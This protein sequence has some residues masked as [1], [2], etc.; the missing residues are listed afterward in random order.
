MNEHHATRT[1]AIGPRR[2]SMI[3][4]LL[5]VTLWSA[6]NVLGQTIQFFPIRSA[7]LGSPPGT[8]G[9]PVTPVFNSALGCWEVQ[10]QAGVEVDLD[11]QGSGWGNAAGSP[12]LVAIQGTVLS[13]GYNN[14]VGGILNPKGWPGSPRNGAYQ[15]ATTC[16]GGDGSPCFTGP[17]GPC[18]AGSCDAN[19]RWIMPPCTIH[20]AAIA[21]PTLNYA[22]AVAVQVDC[23]IDDGMTKTFGGLILDVPNDA[24]GTYVIGLDPAP[25]S[26]FM[27]S[28]LG[29]AIPGVTLTPACIT[30][31]NNNNPGRCCSEI[32]PNVVCEVVTPQVCSTRPQP[33]SFAAGETC[34]GDDA[35]PT[36]ASDGDCGDG[37]A[38]TADVC[39]EAGQC[40]HTIICPE[41]RFYPQRLSKLG[42]PA[43]TIGNSVTPEFNSDLGCWELRV[44]A[45]VEVDID[46]QAFGWGGAP[47]SPTLGAI[48]GTVVSAGYDNGSDGVLNPKGWP[49]SPGDGAYQAGSACS[50]NGDPCNQ[51]F[52]FGCNGGLNGT[53]DHN[54]NWVM[55]DCAADI[56][57]IAA[58]TLDY[59]WVTAA[60]SDCNI[61]DGSVKTMGGLILEVPPDA[62]GTYVIAFDSDPNSSFMT[63]GAGIP[64]PDVALTSA[65]ITVDPP[66]TKNRYLTFAPGESGAVAYKLDMVSSFFHPDAFVSGWIGVPDA[67]GVA[68]LEPNPVTREW[69]EPFVYVTGCEITPVAEF[70]LRASVDDGKTFLPPISLETAPQPIAGKFW[71]DIVGD[72]N[73]VYWEGPNGTTNINDALAIHFTF[74]QRP[75]APHFTR[76]DV[77]SQEPNRV[78]NANDLLFV[79]LA[80]KGEPY[81]FGC[82]DD[83]CEDN[84]F[85]PCP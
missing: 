78:V 42:S 35:C 34:G 48:Q 44:Q 24:A 47:G 57:A 9:D 3:V 38:C 53:C 46:V 12:T 30:I 1:A 49:A 62:T 10:V 18:V 43:G 37:D 79:L 45:G 55:P 63:S 85:E 77:A 66:P 16:D 33:R 51:P 23:A 84:M 61:D 59:V 52:D 29:G 58:P 69:T 67:D 73:G 20:N 27:A 39:N 56:R 17:F 19:P 76:T 80:F 74:Q 13:A 72:F 14:S 31:L 70:E 4:T 81:P 32:G 11:L 22:W 25:N 5:L 8:V 64:I 28:G 71:G 21:T 75:N 15:A 40:G 82:P 36:C 7:P 26:S 41:M 50:G 54:P 68:T 83:P 60:Q 6:T 65:C 2:H